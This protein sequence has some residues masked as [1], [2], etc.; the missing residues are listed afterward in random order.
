MCTRSV[1]LLTAAAVF[2][3]VVA[4]SG[5]PILAQGVPPWSSAST[6]DFES[7]GS[8]PAGPDWSDLFIVTRQ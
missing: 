2:A 3:G 6:P 1:K 7:V 4:F 5:S 8:S